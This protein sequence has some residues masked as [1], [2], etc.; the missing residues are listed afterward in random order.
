MSARTTDFKDGPRMIVFRTVEAMLKADPVLADNVKTW[1]TWDGT[2]NDKLP[3]T[4]QMGP[5]IQLSPVMLPSE[6][7]AVGRRAA[8]LGVRIDTVVAGLIAED[9]VNFW[10]AIEDALQINRPFR[11]STVYCTLQGVSCYVHR[12]DSPGIGGWGAHGNPPTMFLEGTGLLVLRISRT[13]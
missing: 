5:L 6:T 2:G 8:I 13:A 10:D 4:A 7:L 3:F 11:E 9:L 1:S 12:F